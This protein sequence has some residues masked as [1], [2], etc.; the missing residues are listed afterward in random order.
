[1]SQ[2]TLSATTARAIGT[3]HSRRLRHTGVIPGVIYGAGVSPI[4]VGVE[5]AAFRNAVAGEHGLNTVITLSTE[6]TTYTVLA[7]Q[8]QRHPVKG[9]VN[10]IDFQVVDLNA[11]VQASVALHMIGDAVEVRHADWEVEQQLF[12]LT[13][14][15]RPNEIPTHIDVEISHLRPGQSIRVSDLNLPAGVEAVAEPI[16]SVVSTFVGRVAKQGGPEAAAAPDATAGAPAASTD[17]K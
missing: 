8:I 1:M 14:K 10:H 15:A 12:N 16:Q 9:T 6:S 7:R 4:S 11:L 17:G 3:R 2:V 5:A 13:V